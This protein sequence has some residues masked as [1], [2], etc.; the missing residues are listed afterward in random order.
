MRDTEITLT[1]NGNRVEWQRG[2]QENNGTAWKMKEIRKEKLTK[3]G[4]N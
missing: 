3:T 4:V 1:L 2:R